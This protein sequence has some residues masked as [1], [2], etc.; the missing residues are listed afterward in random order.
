[1]NSDHSYIRTTLPG[2][3]GHV[4]YERYFAAKPPIPCAKPLPPEGRCIPPSNAVRFRPAR[5]PACSGVWPVRAGRGLPSPTSISLSVK[6]VAPVAGFSTG[7]PT[8]KKV[9]ATRWL[10]SKNWKAARRRRAS[11]PAPFTPSIWGAALPP[12]WSAS[13][14]MTGQR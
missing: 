7:S 12:P 1:M 2:K 9:I 8:R 6:P 13:V 4:P 10:S 11:P 5:R 3:V 14:P